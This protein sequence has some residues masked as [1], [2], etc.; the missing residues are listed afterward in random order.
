MSPHCS[1]DSN[2]TDKTVSLKPTQISRLQVPNYCTKITR[3]SPSN[4]IIKY[5]NNKKE[6]IGTN[7]DNNLTRNKPKHVNVAPPPQKLTTRH[8]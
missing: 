5:D 4:L 7:V 8:N 6:N 2:S 1:S 3:P